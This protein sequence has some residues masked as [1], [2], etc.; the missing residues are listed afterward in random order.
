MFALDVVRD[1]WHYTRRT[2]KWWLLVLVAG[3]LAIT[4]LMIGAEASLIAPYLYPL[5]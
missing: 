2:R 3:L 5:F 4:W 1:T